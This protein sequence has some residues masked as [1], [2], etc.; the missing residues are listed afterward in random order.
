MVLVMA[1]G[2]E[3][4]VFHLYKN[5]YLEYDFLYTEVYTGLLASD[6]WVSDNMLDTEKNIMS[7]SISFEQLIEEQFSN[8]IESMWRFLYEPSVHDKRKFVFY[9]NQYRYNYL[10]LQYWKSTFEKASFETC[11]FLHQIY[12]Q[13]LRVNTYYKNSIHPHLS[14]RISTQIF[15]LSKED[16]KKLYDTVDSSPFLEE[17]NSEDRS[18]EYLLASYLYNPEDFWREEFLSK[19]EHFTKKLFVE[20]LEVLKGEVLEGAM[21][22]ALSKSLS[23]EEITDEP[24][25]IESTLMLDEGLLWLRDKNIFSETVEYIKD[26][27]SKE[28]FLKMIHSVL[29]ISH[30]DSSDEIL[31]NEASFQVVEAIYSGDCLSLLKRD[32]NRG[33]GSI[34]FN[35]SQRD[36]VNNLFVNYIYRLYQTDKDQLQPFCIR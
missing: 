26:N 1:L 29:S 11:Y 32:I 8:D 2:E 7:T 34:F 22:I 13:N 17:L 21:D 31:K 20:E 24:G 10:Q 5:S 15:P 19:L 14:S 3:G 4:R 18:Y 27:Y 16:Y 30:K 6:S 35:N 12:I 36:K 28:T 9:V 25:L 33:F 23:L